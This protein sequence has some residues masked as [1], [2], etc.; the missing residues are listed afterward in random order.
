MEVHHNAFL[1]FRRLAQ[2]TR[3]C[4]QKSYL[5]SFLAL[6]STL[7]FACLGHPPSDLALDEVDDTLDVIVKPILQLLVMAA[8]LVWCPAV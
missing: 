8:T 3:T 5:T 4:P 7:L 6:L 1:N 2:L